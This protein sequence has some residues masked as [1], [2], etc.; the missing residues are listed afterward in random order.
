M[1]IRPIE[2]LRICLDA[3]AVIDVADGGLLNITG[4]VMR[5]STTDLEDVI[6]SALR[7]RI[8][9]SAAKCVEMLFAHFSAAC[10]T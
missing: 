9:D 7:K 8:A 2:S 10:A 5:I 6:V 4:S 1:H 3:L